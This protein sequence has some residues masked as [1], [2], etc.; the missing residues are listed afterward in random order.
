M[1]KLK[2]RFLNGYNVILAALL[3][4]LGFANSC[5]SVV[6]YGTPNANF[7]V[8]GKVTSEQSGEAI[9]NIRIVMSQD[10]TYGTDSAF[11]DN[12]GNYTIMKGFV[13]PTDLSFLMQFEDIDSSQNGTYQSLDTIVKFIDPEFTDGDGSWFAGETEKEFNISLKEKK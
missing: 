3:A 12:L 1:K 8:N 10:S 11:T 6:E 7:K 9:P 13:F 2:I 4:L 5:D